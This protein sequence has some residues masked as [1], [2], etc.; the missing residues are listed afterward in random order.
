MVSLLQLLWDPCLLPYPLNFRSPPLLPLLP[1]PPFSPPSL[2]GQ[3]LEHSQHNIVSSL[4]ETDSPS[5]QKLLNQ[6]WD[7]VPAFPLHVR[8][9]LAWACSGSSSYEK[10]G[11]EHA[12]KRTHRG[13]KELAIYNPR[14]KVLEKSKVSAP[15]V[16]PPCPQNCEAHFHIH[17]QPWWQLPLT[18]PLVG[19]GPALGRSLGI[20][21]G[22]SLRQSPCQMQGF[23]WQPPL[24]NGY[25]VFQ[26]FQA[27]QGQGE[28]RS[29]WEPSGSWSFLES[30]EGSGPLFPPMC[31]LL[32]K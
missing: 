13:H 29:H 11:L 3:T 1:P 26:N 2:G 17:A 10:K 25:I 8:I 7:F 4:K 30:S 31:C 5:S 18:D 16:W 28:A 9:F 27:Y 19:V 12:R 20:C 21:N 15:W 14:R 23:C 6:D 24:G 32:N 22:R